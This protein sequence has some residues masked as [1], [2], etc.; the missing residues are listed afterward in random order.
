MNNILTA[1]KAI[2]EKAFENLLSI[3]ETKKTI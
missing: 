1:I 2:V 3:N